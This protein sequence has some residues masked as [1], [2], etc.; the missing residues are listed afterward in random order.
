MGQIRA[1]MS[2]LKKSKPILALGL[3]L[4]LS[5][6]AGLPGEKITTPHNNYQIEHI[7]RL[8]NRQKADLYEAVITADMAEH[9]QDHQTAMS[10]YLFA[11][12]LSKN[13]QL[14]DKS[15]SSAIKANDPLGMEQA[16]NVWLEIAP[17]N[18]AAK[19]LLLKSQIIQQNSAAALATSLELM[20]QIETS[21]TRFRVIED[22]IINQ[23]P[24]VSFNLMRD[25]K[26][27]LPQEV[28]IATGLAKFI[29]SLANAN[30]RPQNMLQQALNQINEALVLDSKFIPAIR[31][32]SH[33]LFQL[34][35]D[36]EAR[37]FLSNQF[38][39]NSDSP[40]IS[41]M[42]GQLLYDLRDFE[43]SSAH[44]QDWVST[45]PDDLEAR[46]YLAASFYALEKYKESLE[47]FLPLVDV[48]YK[49]QTT[50]FYCGDSAFKL[51]Q[52]EEAL[53]CLQHVTS[54]RFWTH[55]KIQSAKILAK[56]QQL[57]QAIAILAV[58]EDTDENSRIR[59]VNAEINLLEEYVGVQGAKDRLQAA[60]KDSPDSLVLLLKKIE[61]Y[62]LTDKPTQLMQVL[63]QARGLFTPGDK[64][65]DFNLAAAALLNNNG[66]SKLAVEWLD[67]AVK[68]KPED[69]DLLYTRAIYKEP[70]G[71]YKDMVAEFKH[72]L[73]LYP[74]DLNIQNAL[75]YTL[76]DQGIELNYAKSLI[77]NAF[78]G[79]PN[80]AAVIDSKGWIAY[81]MG[82]LPQAILYLGQAFQMSPTADVAA[83]LG[84]ALWQNDKKDLAKKIWRKGM[85]L[86][87]KNLLLIET[88]K[89]FGVEL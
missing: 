39:E 51:E 79:L 30:K 54:G 85:E 69:K 82:D 16:A 8:D 31:I 71:L 66:H 78:K 57:E 20:R 1:E 56:R 2:D 83:H 47:H 11:A 53:A 26:T 49:L 40:E 38:F 55:A 68:E 65:D 44:F 45:H 52:D 67:E 48:E 70:L 13:Q 58:P 62:E 89:R 88:L 5:A 42:L 50:A 32:K 21:E 28:A 64:L 63:R 22:H 25:L 86:D 72:L 73:K 4:V 87:A 18:V 27:Q 23:D 75:G 37:N 3:S 84:E 15:V 34:R 36:D 46:F 76:A 24:R 60:L 80:N 14:I 29:M 17:D 43:A 77:E 41:Q 10:Y 9:Q 19:S 33:I 81:R 59:L 7:E 12:D 61:L 35:K 6:C 74:D